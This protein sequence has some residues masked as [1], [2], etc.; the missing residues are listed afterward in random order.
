MVGSA[1]GKETKYYFPYEYKDKI[2][3]VD[4]VYDEIP[5]KS[6]VG[7]E[8]VNNGDVISKNIYAKDWDKYNIVI[9]LGRIYKIKI[10]TKNYQPL[11]I[12]SAHKDDIK[13]TEFLN[14]EITLEKGMKVKNNGENK[15]SILAYVHAS[16][17]YPYYKCIDYSEC[18]EK[19][20]I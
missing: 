11:Y 12:E 16:A 14:N 13:E 5:L 4:K 3:L 8:I 1:D 10:K 7:Y 2:K 19:K 20:K 18:N 9:K 17:C 15:N 6:E